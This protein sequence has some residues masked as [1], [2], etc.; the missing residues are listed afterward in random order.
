MSAIEVAGLTVRAGEATLLAGVDL[1]IEAGTWC[2]IVGPNG[3]GKT[4]LVEAVAGLRRPASGTV[5]IGGREIHAMGERARAGCVALVPQH[6]VVPPG[7]SVAA[8]VEL[9]RTAYH[10]VLRA[11]SARDR[12]VVADVLERL[13]LA[14]LAG[15]DVATLSGGERQRAVLARALAQATPVVVLDEPTTGLDLR[16]QVTLLALLRREVAECGLT[17]LATLHDLSLAGQFAD[18]LVLLDRGDIVLDGAPR[19][20]VRH[21][22]LARRY[23]L[24]LRVVDVDGTDVVVPVVPSVTAR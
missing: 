21:E 7:M 6:P 2:T 15:R 5:S 8:Y 3:A 24:T 13:D 16:H 23:G 12:D 9:G 20:V 14:R 17:V 18:R 10:G 1:A 11:P 4:T 19:E 22:E